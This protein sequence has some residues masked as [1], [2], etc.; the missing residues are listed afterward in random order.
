MKWTKVRLKTTVDAEDVV[1]SGLYEI[2][3][4]G[5]EIED[6]VPLTALEKEQLFVDILP[7]ME[8]GE[9]EAYLN[10]YLEEGVDVK[11][12]LEKV[13]VVLK[14]LSEFMDI[15]EGT[16]EV[17]ETEDIDWVNNWKQHFHSFYVDD[18]LI[19]PSWE[20]VKV[21]DEDKLI[22][23][24]DPGTAFGT[25]MHETTQL[26]IRQLR[27][28]VKQGDLVLDIGC[29]SGILGMLALKFGASFSLGTDLDPGAIVAS[30]ENMEGNGI[31]RSRYEVL[32]GN[33]IDDPKV[34]EDVGYDRYHVVVA[35]ILAEV[36]VVLTPVV[37]RCLK[38]GGVYI[39]SGILNEKVDMVREAMGEVGLEV[40]EVTRQGEWA[41]VTGKK[42]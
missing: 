30:H 11:G 19:I 8:V 12:V 4:E 17:S 14:E 18:I 42:G 27:K 21:E 7:E 35:N 41:C 32:I 28:Y 33:V 16:L 10:F 23:R 37:V 39:A 36:L 5:V 6:N 22:V 34:R 40:V 9:G 38:V 25:G 29:G 2:G 20:E 15:G 24:I 26:C 13:R 3:I 31:E 1:I